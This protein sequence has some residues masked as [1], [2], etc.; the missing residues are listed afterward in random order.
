M[1]ENSAYQPELSGRALEG[2]VGPEQWPAEAAGYRHSQQSWI[3]TG[4]EPQKNIAHVGQEMH[5]NTG[6]TP[7]GISVSQECHNSVLISSW[8]DFKPVWGR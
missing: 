4:H 6:G 3:A 8:V 1:E 5:L 7:L 2:G